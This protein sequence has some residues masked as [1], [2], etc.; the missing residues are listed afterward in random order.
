MDNFFYW[1]W[2]RD[3]FLH[4]FLYPFNLI[5]L[6]IVKTKKF[7]YSSGFLKV[8][9]INAKVIVI[10]NLTLGG[11]GK[12][13]IVIDLAERLTLAGKK[14]GIISRGYKGVREVDP[15]LVDGSASVESCGDEALM[16]KETLHLPVVVGVKRVEAANL[17]LKHY[18]VDVILSDD[19]LQ[20]F[21]L[22]RDHEI[23]VSSDSLSNRNRLMVPFGPY[24]SSIHDHLSAD[25]YFNKGGGT[26]AA[27]GFTLEPSLLFSLS[28]GCSVDFSV[29]D[30]NFHA[31][32]AIADPD[33]FFK[34]ITKYRSDFYRHKFPD[35]H[36]FSIQELTFDDG[37]PIIMTKKDAV[38]CKNYTHLP[39]YYVDA[40]VKYEG[41]GEEII[42]TYIESML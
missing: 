19:G 32:T 20:H 28:D 14:V 15:L 25:L 3:K 41:A 21:Q 5:P 12:T 18:D 17:L 26:G 22:G 23:I 35:H 27:I 8:S 16:M 39:I 1:L 9:K 2:Y 42:N 7:L 34:T 6:L 37:L 13:P 31:V 36:Y 29:F 40:K 38:K 10:G 11:T 33:H 4:L 30:N 24:R